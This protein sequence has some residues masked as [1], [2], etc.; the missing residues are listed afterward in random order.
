[1]FAASKERIDKILFPY[2]QICILVESCWTSAKVARSTNGLEPNRTQVGQ[3]NQFS[4]WTVWIGLSGRSAEAAGQ[5][6]EHSGPVQ[7]QY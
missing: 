7:C 5:S 6:G 4:H 1:M 2:S 3:F